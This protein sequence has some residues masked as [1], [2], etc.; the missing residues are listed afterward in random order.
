MKIIY[1]IA[2]EGMGHA[3]RSKVVIDYLKTKHNVIVVT[4]GRSYKLF[5]GNYDNV[6]QISGLFM[7]YKDNSFRYV[8]TAVDNVLK[9]F[10][11]LSSVKTISKLIKDENVD[12]LISDF[13]PLSIVAAKKSKI[14]IICVDNQQAL[15]YSKV[16]TSLFKL[17]HPA[18]VR[19]Y[20]RRTTKQAN[21]FFVSSFFPLDIN[22][23]NVDVVAPIIRRDLL[24][25]NPLNMGHVLVYQTSRSNK[26][27]IKVLKSVESQKFIVYGFDIEKVSDNVTFKKF[28]EKTM[29]LDLS[30]AKAV[31]T[32][33][34]YSLISEAI[35]LR[36][37]ILCEPVKDQFEQML[38]AQKVKQLG[39]GGIVDRL[40]SKSIVSFLN[41]VD[42]FKKRL[43]MREIQRDN[44]ALF[45]LLDKKIEELV[46]N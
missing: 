2:G 10:K 17:A 33:G 43:E 29:I 38:N 30:S 9:T 34:G 28:D 35:N 1:A 18:V 20:I 22:K 3:T 41:K 44:N 7:S 32:N 40:S 13:E 12:L 46:K 8:K 16:N 23:S 24:A 21:H 42:M 5:K 26:D 14:P 15:L 27:L 6:H 31:I 11:N 4:S 36:K 19:N 45:R 39:Y 37:P 25:S